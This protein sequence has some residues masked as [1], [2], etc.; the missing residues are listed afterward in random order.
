M[1]RRG[2]FLFLWPWFLGAQLIPVRLGPSIAVTPPALDASGRTVVFGSSVDVQGRVTSTTDLYVSA[3]DGSGLRRLTNYGTVDVTAP[4]GITEVSLSKTGAQAAVVALLPAKGGGTGQLHVIDTA[5]GSDRAIGADTQGCVLPL[6]PVATLFSCIHSPHFTPDGKRILFSVN[7]NQ[8]FMIVNGD[9]TGLASLPIFSG[10]LAAGPQRV[11]SRDGLLVF[12]SAAPSG[13]TF[14]AS[15]T[16]VY[17]A[18]LDGTGLRDLTKLG[19]N[20]QLFCRDA[21]ISDDGKTVVF[22]TNFAGNRTGASPVV[23]IWTVQ[24]DGTGLR[25]LT[26][27]SDPSSQPSLSADGITVAFTQSGQIHVLRL[28]KNLVPP[29]TKFQFSVAE[30][31]VISDDASLIAFTSGPTAGQTGAIYSV[32]PDGSNLH[33]VYAPRALSPNGVVSLVLGFPPSRG[34]LITVYGTNLN[35]DQITSAS[36][37]PLP[38][39][40]AGVRVLVNGRPIPMVSVTPWQ[41][42]AQAPQ[43]LPAGTVNVQLAF[44]DGS[45]S[46]SD[47]VNL[48]NSAPVPFTQLR[49]S[50]GG[51]SDYWQ[52]AAFHAGTGTLADDG[53]P[54]APKEVLEMFGVGIGPTNPA[55]PGGMPSPANPPA[56]ARLTP[57]VQ[58]GGQRAR[59]LF[60]GLVPGLAGIYQVN[61]VVPDGLKSGRQPVVW[62]SRQFRFAGPG[63]ISI[64]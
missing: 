61:V 8:P 15:A 50:A 31:P 27:G 40:L 59:V 44:A 54:A 41:I 36:G 26:S 23:Q 30:H 7:R 48:L 64:R 60:A 20:S 11:I 52:I 3:P 56:R 58:I 9:G 5:T 43:D 49:K 22:E 18:N 46:L 62:Q 35:S 25:Q 28:D 39:N 57:E 16:D 37:F 53:N 45:S 12:T 33:Q 34:S 19:N 29:V 14:A 6:A 55:V 1:K 32:K 24:S 2:A 42:D 10:S 38:D 21:T 47:S 13:P 51:D 4:E 63:T 17:V